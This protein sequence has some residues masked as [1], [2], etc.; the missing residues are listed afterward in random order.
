MT[1]TERTI[2]KAYARCDMNIQKTADRLSYHRR[3][4]VY[5]FNKI[6]KQYK[7]NPKRFYDL[8]RLIDYINNCETDTFIFGVYYNIDETDL[9][10]IKIKAENER[11]AWEKLRELVSDA[12]DR[13]RVIYLKDNSDEI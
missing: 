9:I 11:E 1:E 6:K 13:T 4:I 8:K 3:S 2:I 10:E 12:S 7:L 5:H